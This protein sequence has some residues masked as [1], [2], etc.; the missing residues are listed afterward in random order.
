MTRRLQIIGK[1]FRVLFWALRFRVFRW[2]DFVRAYLTIERS[3]LFDGEFYRNGLA[4]ANSHRMDPLAHYLARG[5]REGRDPHALFDTRF[6][7]EKNPEVMQS[8]LSPLFHFIERG[9]PAGRSPHPLFDTAYYLKKY[10]DV[11]A[12]GMNPLTHYLTYGAKDGRNPSPLFDTAYY[13]MKNPEVVRTPCHPL[14]HYLQRGAWEKR[15]P[16]PLFQSGYY[17]TKNPDVAAS[18]VNPLVHYIEFG[19]REGR[20]PNP[21]FDTA[22]YLEENPEVADSGVNPLSHYIEEG[23]GR[24][25]NPGPLFDMDYYVRMYPDVLES[26]VNPLVHYLEF[27][28]REGRYPNNVYEIWLRQHQLTE[29]D[30]KRIAA[31]IP[32]LSYQ[33]L[34]SII[35]PVFNTGERWLRK[36][37]DSV[38]SQLYPHWEL[39]IADD[40]STKPHV[41]KILEEYAS[42]DPRIR[43][44]FRKEN[45]HISACSNSAL[46][47]VRGEFIALLDHDDE[48]SVDALYENAVLM[49]HHRDADMIY[50]DEDKIN[51][52]GERH[53]PF[54]KP[55]WSPDTFLSHMYTCHLGVYRTGLIRKIGGFRVGFE[56]SQDYDLVLRFTEQTT[57]IHHIPKVL[58]HWR[59][60]K[61]STALTHDAKNYA[62]ISGLKA[63]REALDRRGEKGWVEHVA[64]YPGQYLVHYPVPGNPKMTILIPTRDNA[65][66][67]DRCLESLFSKTSY[68]NFEVI[69][70]DNG[71]EKPETKDFFARWRKQE[72]GRLRILRV[73]IPFNFSR[74][75]NEGARHAEGDLLCL[76][77]DDTEIIEPDW[78]E[79]MAGQACRPSVGAV[80]AFLLYPDDRIQHA[81]L[82]LGIVGPAN[83]GH[84]G[85]PSD[86]AGYFGRLLVVYNYA[87]V[88]GACLMVRKQLYL[89]M[90][91]LDE[92][93]VVAYN[94]VD[95]CLRLLQKGYRN[96]VLPQVRLYHHESGSRGSDRFGENQGRLMRETD[97]MNERWK[98]WIRNDPFYSPHLTREREDFTLQKFSID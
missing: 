3:G 71:S 80:G 24:G 15:N 50:S 28:M 54:F 40:A 27:G 75:N 1:I 7:R 5:S 51:E 38:L 23:S 49:N 2:V 69:L 61:G 97:L 47:M 83:H 92:G 91:G 11:A 68:R 32:S 52:E 89:E 81:G 56:G 59:T 29:E 62:Y 18:G 84:K 63:L 17:L 37:L 86:S 35:V 87:A 95:F 41:R 46:E 9:A 6:Y 8:G 13:L 53:S 31:E 76:L 55:D 60:I 44:A 78:L 10:P 72:S 66:C 58:Y 85:M 21:M 14:V 73:D 79:E 36:C 4:G 70:I 42:R 30:R 48:L 82:I 67:L 65:A 39:C 45:G 93:L 25:L 77:N 20:K 74:L 12:A 98:E 16:H 26:K 34:F 64:G 43:V 94:D 57:K 90:G 19:A 33:P 22:F 96:V 88:T